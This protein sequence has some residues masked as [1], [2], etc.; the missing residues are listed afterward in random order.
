[1]LVNS[2]D[3]LSALKNKQIA[4]AVLD[5]LEQEPPPEDHPLIVALQ[6]NTLDNLKI[7][8]HIAWA[9]N[10]SQQRLIHMLSNNIAAFKRGERLNR[11]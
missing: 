9:S 5:V 2:V 3:L 6:Q 1:M 4:Y 10:E 7:T 11:L 8:A